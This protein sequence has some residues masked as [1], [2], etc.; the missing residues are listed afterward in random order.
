MH[1]FY[2]FIY[3]HPW[4]LIDGNAESVI[5]KI[6]GWGINGI[7]IA[8]SYHAGYF[9]HSHN[10]DH[11][12]YMSEDG[13]VYF[14]PTKRYFQTTSIQPRQAEISKNFDCLGKAQELCRKYG[15]KMMSWTVCN[16]NTP[17]GIQN[18]QHTIKNVFEDSYPHALCPSSNDV[19][20]FVRGICENLS[21]NYDFDSIVLEANDFRGIPHGHHHERYG[22]VL[23]HLEELLMSLCFCQWCINRANQNGLDLIPVSQNIRKHLE[24]YFNEAP[25]FPNNLPSD[26]NQMLESYPDLIDMIAFRK[27]VE[28]SLVSEINT[29]LKQIGNTSLLA[30]SLFRNDYS[31][32]IDAFV[33]SCYGNSIKEIQANITSQRN[34]AG[35]KTL[36][37]GIRTGFGEVLSQT[38]LIEMVESVQRGGANGIGFYNYSET[39]M[40]V[41]N[42]IGPALEPFR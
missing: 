7:N 16:H 40:K 23:R 6:A 35:N 19:R 28:S 30:Q 27:D 20:R 1:K 11:K 26:L 36:F 14:E 29:D 33:V 25:T 39:P 5:E 21:A 10:P 3:L 38:S 22:T 37:A 2:S 24:I 8:T 31:P 4:D 17:L 13:V 12:M 41:L 9:L 15:L 42:W 32:S 18:P 34:I